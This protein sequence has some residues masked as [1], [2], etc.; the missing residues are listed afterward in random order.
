MVN[1]NVMGD[2]KTTQA[3]Q[4]Q[5]RAA[6][7]PQILMTAVERLVAIMEQ[8]SEW[9]QQNQV[10]LISSTLAEKY[11]IIAFLGG[12][13]ALLR[14]DNEWHLQLSEQ[15]KQIWNVLLARLSESS[16]L[17]ME[18][19]TK[20]KGYK[21]VMMRCITQAIDKV[22]NKHNHYDYKGRM[23]TPRTPVITASLSF[24]QQT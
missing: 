9:L 6:C 24:N 8:E 2:H 1:V 15:D 7:N 14:E 10:E 5:V 11:D 20:I 18:A 19:I 3:D 22:C 16:R 12:Q 13:E 4:N 23:R 21:E 17:N